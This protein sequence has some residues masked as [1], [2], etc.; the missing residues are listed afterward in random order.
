[1]FADYVK[2]GVKAALVITVTTAIVLVFTNI[3]IHIPSIDL[4]PLYAAIG[5][6][7][8]IVA[9][10]APPLLPFINFLTFLL[11]FEIATYALYIELIAWRWV[12]KINE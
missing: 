8:A 9:Y 11:I 7:K 10:W 5:T 12:L 4:L 6:G 1:M 2:M 3:N